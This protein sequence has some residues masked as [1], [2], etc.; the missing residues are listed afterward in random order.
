MSSWWYNS[1]VADFGVAGI[2]GERGSLDR[3]VVPPTFFTADTWEETIAVTTSSQAGIWVKNGAGEWALRKPGVVNAGSLAV[4]R[5]ATCAVIAGWLHVPSPVVELVQ[6]PSYGPSSIS[7]EVAGAFTW[8]NVM[9]MKLSDELYA[10][11][12][13]AL[14]AYAGPVIVLDALLGAVDRYNS[15]NHLYA[16]NERRWYTIDYGYSFNRWSTQNDDGL[17]GVG[18][19]SLPYGW[20]APPWGH[21]YPEII[22]AACSAPDLFCKALALAES[23]PDDRFDALLRLPTSDFASR[24]DCVSM[25]DFLK[26]RRANLRKLLRPWCNAN[27]L[28]QALAAA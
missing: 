23:I 12:T 2:Q 15:G 8:H 7:H 14:Q 1:A 27:G 10:D 6:H 17:R 9:N 3:F 26:H 21:V 25:A 18:D 16:E 20:A 5:E 22:Q 24:S 28:G 11:G 4:V 13:L 19:S